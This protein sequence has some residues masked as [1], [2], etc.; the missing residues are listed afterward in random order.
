MPSRVASSDTL[1]V[2]GL[3]DLDKAWLVAGVE[4]QKSYR[5]SLGSIAEPVRVDA[6]RLAAGAGRGLDEGDPWT[7]MRAVV[8]RTGVYV[9]PVQRGRR[10]RRNPQLRRPNLAALLMDRAMQPALEG[11]VREVEARFDEL[12]GGMASAWERA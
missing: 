4:Y 12:L 8:R 9:A 3:A 11:N 1:R 6:E 2:Q 7:K 10:T 5:A